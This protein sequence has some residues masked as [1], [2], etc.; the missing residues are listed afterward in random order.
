MRK[1]IGSFVASNHRALLLLG[2]LLS[3]AAV[4]VLT[5]RSS[6]Q[7]RSSDSSRTG[8]ENR[9]VDNPVIMA[10]AAD[11]DL[12]AAFGTGQASVPA[13]VA[14]TFFGANSPAIIDEV[15]SIGLQSSG[16]IIAAGTSGTQF[17]LVRYTTAGTLD[18]A[19]GPGGSG[20]KVAVP[21]FFANVGNDRV[22]D[23]V[24]SSAAT[25]TDK[26]VMVGGTANNAMVNPCSTGMSF[27]ID[28]GI[29]VRNANG[30]PDTTFN[31]TGQRTVDFFGCA[32]VAHAVVVQPD[33]KIVVIGTAHDP[34]PLPGD[35]DD[36]NYVVLARYNANGTVDTTFN[37]GV[38]G[39]TT[40][41]VRYVTPT[42]TIGYFDMAIIPVGDPNAGKFI[43]VG[44]NGDFVL[45]RFNSNGSKDATFAGAGTVITD[46][47]G[48]SVTD[49]ANSVALYPDGRII[50]AGDTSVG[51]NFALARYSS[52]GVLDTGGFG[53][54]GTGGKV[55]TDVSSG[56]GDDS[57]KSVSL[58]PNGKIV[59][60][61][62]AI[63]LGGSSGTLPALGIAR[64][65]SNGTL[66]TTFKTTGKLVISFGANGAN[67]NRAPN[68]PAGMLQ[69]DGKIL[70]GG[71]IAADFLN[72]SDFFV[73]RFQNT[74]AK[75]PFDFDGDNK[76]DVSIF[77]PGPGEW[78]YLKSSNG[79]NAAAQF[80]AGT[81][82]IT[83]G[84]FTGDGKADLAFFRPST[85]NWFV[86]RSNDFS[87]FAFPFGLSGDVPMP[88]DYDNDGKTDAAVFRPST[89]T[90]FIL[91]SGGS[92]TTIAPFGIAGD[93]PVAADY[94][95][96]GRADIA[97][98][99]PGPREW[100]I[101][102]STAGLI[103]F[104]FGA[105]GDK[106]V[107]GDYTGDGKAD[108]AFWRPSTGEWFI[109]RSE[110][111]S[112]F[113]FPFGVSTDIP[114]PGDYDGDGKI[115]AGVFRPS[116]SLWFVLR[117]T[118]GQL[119]VPFGQAGDL[120]VPNAFVRN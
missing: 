105:A 6:A 29:A 89:S 19:F 99:R 17:A 9:A 118:A 69:A 108:V 22:A 35:S 114:S 26:I 38:G 3:L 70:A 85:G 68:A 112:F 110:N 67:A 84:D 79:T 91:N 13:G 66:D 104:Q 117:S 32:D 92:P 76:T 16:Q 96:D 93:V 78:W 64:Y 31:A 119:I 52:A 39:N 30:T 14:R 24:V 86:L 46:I 45:N 109:L 87:F 75:S 37:G 60:T 97:I 48:V 74:S 50:V 10:P 2:V 28:W 111:Q 103:A 8:K 72:D 81:D 12:D 51:A 58:M 63:G 21:R 7:N 47:G 65:N 80:G 83:P 88:A 4:S 25:S 73:A 27:P 18:T 59:A 49:N 71:T 115:D 20:G 90:W 101:Q 98:F 82:R 15:E 62:E 55:I 100:W 41:Q 116:N 53:T 102:R 54:T 1:S 120:P 77:R 40:G 43:T 34:G 11:G 56:N 5:W 42:N 107:P 94:D 95:G 23:M 33:G 113:A 36:V 57:S 106:T 44:S 61:G